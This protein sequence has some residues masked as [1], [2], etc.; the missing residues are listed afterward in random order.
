MKK[1]ETYPTNLYPEYANKSTTVPSPPIFNRYVPNFIIINSKKTMPD[2][3]MLSWDEHDESSKKVSSP[4]D[5]DAAL[6]SSSGP[7]LD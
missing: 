1:D 2:V 3:Q 5:L 7:N 4:S 6:P